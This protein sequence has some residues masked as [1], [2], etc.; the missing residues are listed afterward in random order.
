MRELKPCLD[1]D[2]GRFA[3]HTAISGN[4][5]KPLNS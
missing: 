3:F 2:G 1:F 5:V 4:E